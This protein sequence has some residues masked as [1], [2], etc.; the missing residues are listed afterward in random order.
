MG[1]QLGSAY[2][3]IDIDTSGA[4]AAVDALFGTLDGVGQRLR[5]VGGGMTA[6]V[7]APVVAGATVAYKAATDLNASIADLNVVGGDSERWTG[8]LQ[9][10]MVTAA[11]SLDD[12]SNA[13]FTYISVMGDSAA[14]AS[15]FDAIARAS[16]A[17]MTNMETVNSAVT[18][19]MKAYGMEA[20]AA[21]ELTDK[22]LVAAGNSPSDLGDYATVLAQVSSTSSAFGVSLDEQLA[23]LTQ[24]S[25]QYPTLAEAG[26]G[27][28]NLL[29]QVVKP[30]GDLAAMMAD[31]G[32]ESGA[33]MV[34]QEGLYGSLQMIKQAADESGVGLESLFGSQ[35]A[36]GAAVRLLNSDT[37]AYAGLLGQL[38]TAQ[39]T[40][41][42]LYAVQTEGANAAGFAQQQMGKEI[43]VV[44]QDLGQALVPAFQA[45]L[46]AAEPL[47]EGVKSLVSWFTSLSPKT[48][49]N[50]IKVVAL[51]AVIGPLVGG[52]GMVVGAV[53]TLAPLFTGLASAVALL[54]SPVGIVLGLVAG[55]AAVMFNWGGANEKV[56]ETLEGWGLEG[57]AEGVRSL[58]EWTQKVVDAVTALING[59]M[60]F[61]D[62]FAA[63]KPEWL[64]TLG[65]WNWPAW[66]TT[67]EWLTKLVDWAWPGMGDAPE[68]VQSVVGFAWPLL[69]P[70]AWVQSLVDWAWPMLA[71]IP[72]IADLVAWLWPKL[73]VPEW[74][75]TLFSWAWPLLGPIAWIVKLTSWAWPSLSKPDWIQ[76]L[77]DFQWPGFPT[78][79]G[80]LGGGGDADQNAMGTNFFRGGAT[81]VG[82]Q[83][84]ELIELPRGTKIFD[85]NESMRM[86]G[87]TASGVT[88]QFNG[89]VYMQGE[90]D[91]DALTRRIVQRLRWNQL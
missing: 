58:H 72:W 21:A 90:A 43:Q 74:V 9:D 38:N 45:A 85:N 91:V 32:Y 50:I 35:E 48:Q 71:E 75:S 26:T 36:L 84:P 13:A 52:L 64:T 57:V 39:G 11:T 27:Y 65:E 44:A 40:T 54:F 69:M 49:Q 15:D 68:W 41:N 24:L 42:E 79:P 14:A 63:V 10:G 80:W 55:I 8:L 18:S 6:G 89:P 16:V 33:A 77:L 70:V 46:Q 37:E 22:F 73:E 53:T 29:S 61:A 59:E 34:E 81:W 25:Q 67:P 7:T 78:R 17:G 12:A 51:A 60:S 62:F 1:V 28:K 5:S 47:I 19:T 86:A 88:V 66:P 76:R 4:K 20:G 56:A 83:G 82:E 2:G 31:M 3:Q 87:A 23:M 30:T